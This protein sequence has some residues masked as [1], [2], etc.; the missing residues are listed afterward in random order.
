MK[1]GIDGRARTLQNGKRKES[2]K[3][4]AKNRC[5]NQLCMRFLPRQ[6][7]RLLAC[8]AY[9]HARRDGEF[10]CLYCKHSEKE[11][12]IFC[13][14]SEQDTQEKNNQRAEMLPL[15]GQVA[16][17]AY[18]P[19]HN[20]A[21]SRRRSPMCAC[22]RTAFSA[23]VRSLEG[24]V[25]SWLFRQCAG[26]SRD[27]VVLLEEETGRLECQPRN[28]AR[29]PRCNRLFF[30]YFLLRARCT[31]SFSSIRAR[32]QRSAM[33][34]CSKVSPGGSVTRTCRIPRYIKKRPA[35]EPP[36]IERRAQEHCCLFS[37]SVS[38]PRLT[39]Y[40]RIIGHHQS[41]L[42]KEGGT[43]GRRPTSTRDPWRRGALLCPGTGRPRAR[44][45]D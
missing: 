34:E 24:S 11:T 27:V 38:L 10:R 19:L 17:K 13:G 33:L 41:R 18:S 26:G 20:N 28:S 37:L 23:K 30:I 1:Y 9:N 2:G 40:H 25:F 16:S 42:S 21:T 44:N 32:T 43:A 5:R 8:S 22:I 45:R 3:L 15:L 12:D 36:Y 29:D 14:T 39:I 35:A 6:L 31:S 7:S 4:R